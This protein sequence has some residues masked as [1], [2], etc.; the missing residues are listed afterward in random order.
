MLKAKQHEYSDKLNSLKDELGHTLYLHGETLSEYRDR[1]DC[2][3]ADDSFESINDDDE[4][5][6]ILPPHKSNPAEFGNLDRG[7]RHNESELRRFQNYETDTV[8]DHLNRPGLYNNRDLEDRL[9]DIFRHIDDFRRFLFD[10]CDD[11][12]SAWF[13]MNTVTVRNLGEIQDEIHEI[14]GRI[15]RMEDP[16]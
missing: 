14:N 15:S 2:D 4:M 11:I 12:Y 9:D 5:T 7:L 10:F 8:F 13:A 3:S 6:R 16:Y 1:S